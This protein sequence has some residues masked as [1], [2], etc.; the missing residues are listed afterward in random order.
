LLLLL[1]L[2]LCNSLL[3][4]SPLLLLLLPPPPPPTGKGYMDNTPQEQM[5]EERLNKIESKN[6]NNSVEDNLAR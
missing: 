1:L 6:R 3:I 5:Q 4:P 2:L